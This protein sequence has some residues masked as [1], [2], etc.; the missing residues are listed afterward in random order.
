[1]DVKQLLMIVILLSLC[2]QV[3]TER[4]FYK[5][6]GVSRDASTKQIKK[7]YRSLAMKFHPD[8]NPDPD[9]QTKFHD[10]NEA[11]EVLSD[12]EKRE[13][14]NRY[15]EEGLKKNQGHHHGSDIF[16][17]FFGGS[18]GF[19]FGQADDGHREIPRGGT[20]TMDLEVSLADLYIGQTI[21][22]ARFKPVAQAATGTRKCNCRME[23]KT[24]PL[25]P[26]RFQMVQQEACDE[27]PNIKY[28]NEETILEVEIEPG[29]E[30]GYQYP[31]VSEGEPHVDG[32]PGDL[33]LVIRQKRNA[34]FQRR[35]DDLYTNVTISLRDALVGFEMDITHLD[36]HKVHIAREKI[37]WPGAMVMKQGE[38]M[39][40]YENNLK[41]GNLY[42]TFDV[43][44][45]R[46]TFED[47]DKE[48]IIRVLEQESSQKPYNGL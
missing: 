31:F 13:V 23:M 29:M 11:Y 30:D 7:A 4:D 12:D 42:I 44:F 41:R 5:I 32:E 45:P 47:Q 25:G 1:M 16:S 10:I 39:P 48:D 26:G 14:Y 37:T 20:I 21:N 2:Y 36:R 34:V 6:L 3:L 19:R 40:N 22:I 27:C 17:S 33:I 43:N 9:S 18:F 15:G 28:E 38:G 24:I 8:K 35:G 46:G